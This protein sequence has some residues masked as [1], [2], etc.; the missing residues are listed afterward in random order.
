MPRK[1]PPVWPKGTRP[2]DSGRKKGTPNRISVEVKALVAQLMNDV[3]YQHQLRDDFRRRKVHPTVEALIWSY[4]LGRPTQPIDITASVD[5]NARLEEER[6]IFATLD[7]ADLEQLA[8]KSQGLVDRALALSRARLAAAAIP[9]PRGDEA[10]SDPPARPPTQVG[11]LNNL[12]HP[13]VVPPHIA[14]RQK[15]QVFWVCHNSV[16]L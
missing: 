12:L 14:E 7:L 5:V 11:R 6:R 4:H 15:C 10:G 8:A 9:P 2:P 3:A 13:P 1:P 16:P